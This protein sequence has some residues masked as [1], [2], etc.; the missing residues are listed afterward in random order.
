MRQFIIA[1]KWTSPLS[2][3]KQSVDRQGVPFCTCWPVWMCARTKPFREKYWRWGKKKP[4][5]FKT[6]QTKLCKVVTTDHTRCYLKSVI[7]TLYC[8]RKYRSLSLKH[9]VASGPH[10]MQSSVR[11]FTTL[12]VTWLCGDAPVSRPWI[13]TFLI[14]LDYFCIERM[15]RFILFP[16]VA[17]KQLLLSSVRN[18]N[19]L[20]L[21]GPSKTELLACTPSLH[22]LTLNVDYKFDS[23]A[24]IFSPVPHF[25]IAEFHF[26]STVHRTLPFVKKW[27][28]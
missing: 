19:A 22:R 11:S 5:M 3:H 1:S 20:L 6:K 26:R 27:M 2:L 28:I 9:C 18:Q 8:S 15:I 14:D 21:F 24:L 10:T 7:M 12:Q 25:A 4:E 23:S 13:I 17:E 16:Q